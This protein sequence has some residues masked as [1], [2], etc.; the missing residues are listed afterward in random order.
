MTHFENQKKL[1]NSLL[2]RMPT[3]DLEVRISKIPGAPRGPVPALTPLQI[4][5]NAKC[6]MGPID[7]LAELEEASKNTGPVDTPQEEQRVRL[8]P[9]P[10]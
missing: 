10:R 2:N 7:T 1:K 3:T 6:H 8:T 5:N 4:A 9:S